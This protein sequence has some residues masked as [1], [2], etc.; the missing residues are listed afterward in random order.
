MRASWTPHVIKRPNIIIKRPQKGLS[1]TS[2]NQE[3]HCICNSHLSL[4]FS[5]PDIQ[6]H[7]VGIMGDLH[8]APEQMH[9][10]NTVRVF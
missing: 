7:V 10:F 4:G 5:N 9:L 1:M 2:S 8:L 6:R 3:R